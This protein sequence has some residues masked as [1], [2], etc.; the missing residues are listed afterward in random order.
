MIEKYVGYKVGFMP[1]VKDVD[2]DPGT[3]EMWDSDD[4]YWLACYGEWV[5][6]KKKPP[7]KLVL[8]G[9]ELFDDFPSFY[10]G[11]IDMVMGE[12]LEMRLAFDK[13]SKHL[14]PVGERNLIKGV[15][16][17]YNSLLTSKKETV[18]V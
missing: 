4:T 1:G 15:I 3:G 9:T 18:T 11:L 10:I 2:F 7:K 5:D 6:S 14:I 13:E 8:C 16:K 12:D 17:F